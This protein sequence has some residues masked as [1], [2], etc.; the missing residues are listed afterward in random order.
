MMMNRKWISYGFLFVGVL[1]IFISAISL[2]FGYRIRELWP[3]TIVLY[4][5]GGI[6]ILGAFGVIFLGISA[7][8]HALSSKCML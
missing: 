4:D 6:V 1:F 5:T 2:I 3:S 8:L 7:P